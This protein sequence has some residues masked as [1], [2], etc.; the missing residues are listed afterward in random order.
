MSTMYTYNG[1]S[2][3]N[4]FLNFVNLFPVCSVQLRNLMVKTKVL[5]YKENGDYE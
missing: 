5:L 1:A 3:T 2:V 4:V